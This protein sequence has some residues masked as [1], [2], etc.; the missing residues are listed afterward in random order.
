MKNVKQNVKA[1][2]TRAYKQKNKTA[3]EIAKRLF[4]IIGALMASLLLLIPGLIVAIVIFVVDPGNP[5]F[6]Q[7]RMGRYYKRIKVVKFRSMVKNADDLKNMLTP[8]QYD[9]YLKEFKLDDDPRFLPHR[10]GHYL[11]RLSIDEIPQIMFNVLIAGNMSFVG[12]RPILKDELEMNYT[13]DEQ[14]MLLSVKPGITGYWQ[15]Y[16]RNAI[17]YEN[18]ERQAMEL[19]YVKNRSI[20]FDVKIMFKTISAVLKREGAQ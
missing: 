6:I 17:V 14:E 19:Y 10:I 1:K 20:W 5:F 15:A 7:E 3:Y 12:P 4:D 16:G 8:E 18:G 9:Q 2:E 11:R 13:P